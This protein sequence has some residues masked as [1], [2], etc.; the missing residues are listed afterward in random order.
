MA[1]VAVIKESRDGETRVA[2]VPETVKKLIGAGFSVMFE[3]GAGAAATY[4]DADYQAAGATVA[5]TA[6]AALSAADVVLKVRAPSVD[7][8][9]ALKSGA[10]LVALLD[11]HRDKTALAALAARG[12]TA[13]AMEFVPRI[14]RAQA[15]DAL[16]SQA[17]LA[18][19]R[20]V[21]EAAWAF[22]KALPMMMT[23]AGTIA[24]ARVFVMGVGV[25]GL[26][27]I[28][29]ARRLGAVVT[30]TDVRPATRE[31]VE[32]L[33]AKFLAVEDE[34]SVSAQTAGGYAREMSAGYQARQA[35][36]VSAHIA[37][38]DIVITTALIPGRPAPR[39]VSAA[40]VASMRAGSVIL[41]LAVEQGGNVE[42]VRLGEVAMTPNGV[43]I[44][45]FP[46]LPGRVAADASALYARN[47]MAFAGLLLDEA[48]ALAP[49]YE[50]EIL[51]AA[52]VVRG[53]AV[54]HP[55]LA[56]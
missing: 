34:E 45:G 13:F 44:L 53:G 2:A 43:K 36:L 27:A 9:V 25:A 14:T 41:D 26:Q 42:D 22:G 35:E 4:L 38:Q 39:L 40:Q 19:Y 47:L 48:G 15:M 56:S 8:A 54:V 51:K 46:N 17:N 21:I 23:A 37:K 31:Q 33:G 32:S 7:E 29:T 49:D 50:D 6:R 3:A 30:A 10:L 1:V 11:P 55:A 28:A 16:S 5:P 18:G 52:L 20:A 24:P 12:V